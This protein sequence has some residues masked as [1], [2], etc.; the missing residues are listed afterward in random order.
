[1]NTSIMH[2]K[3]VDG[4]ELLEILNSNSILRLLARFS[5]FGVM[6]VVES[7]WGCVLTGSFCKITE[8][9]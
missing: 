1:M 6:N 3:F 2:N 8:G 4:L 5:V 7:V 9:H